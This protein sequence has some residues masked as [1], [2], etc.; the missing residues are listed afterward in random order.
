MPTIITNSNISPI[1]KFNFKTR[2]QARHEGILK[3]F[4]LMKGK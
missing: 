4:Q 2:E 1:R 3:V